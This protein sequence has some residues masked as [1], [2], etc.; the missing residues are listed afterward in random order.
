MV[1]WVIV[2]E[3]KAVRPSQLIRGVRRTSGMG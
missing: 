3:G 2:N 1:G